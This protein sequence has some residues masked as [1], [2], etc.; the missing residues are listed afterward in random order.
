MSKLLFYTT[1]RFKVQKTV[2][3]KHNVKS[4]VLQGYDVKILEVYHYACILQSYNN[5]K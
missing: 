3:D 4:Q 1:K 5:E 2:Q